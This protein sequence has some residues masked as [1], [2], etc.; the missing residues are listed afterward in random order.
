MNFVQMFQDDYTK[1]LS[2]T[3]VA[4]ASLIVHYVISSIVGMIFNMVVHNQFVYL[5]FPVGL[6]GLVT[7]LYWGNKAAS[8]TSTIKGPTP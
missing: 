7:L 2:L 4:C 1:E 5:D 8:T 6:A 3:R